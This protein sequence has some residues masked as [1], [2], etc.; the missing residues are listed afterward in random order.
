MTRGFWK[1]QAAELDWAAPWTRTVDWDNAPF[2]RWFVGGRL[3]AAVNCV[4]RHV[5]A[6][7]GDRVAPHWV[8]EPAGDTR[9]LTYAE[10]K[11]E[12][13]RAANALTE[14]GAR[15]GDRVAI[16]LPM[17]PEAVI[18]M[19][20]CARIGAPHTVV[21]GGFSA[22][23]LASRLVDRTARIV[24]TAD[25][26]YRRG[27]PS[28][29]KP[30]VDEAHIKA[31]DQG[32]TV[33]RVLV[34]RRTG[35]EPGSN[36]RSARIQRSLSPRSSGQVTRTPARLCARSSFSPVMKVWTSSK[37]CDDTSGP[38][39]GRLPP[40]VRSQSSRSSPRLCRARSCDAWLRDIAERRKVGT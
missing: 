26:G 11:E 2:A 5:A 33:E 32:V 36:Q 12:F 8:G 6:G 1:E 22:D 14:L 3:N 25:G 30:A 16:H 23:A 38:R 24:I 4:D 40:H 15:T 37:S 29:V 34:V 13:C 7:R 27:A 21:F 10:L 28:A 17:T 20:A 35:E 18:A 39:S 9:D 31:A 19:L